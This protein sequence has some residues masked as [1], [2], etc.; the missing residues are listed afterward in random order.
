MR[1]RYTRASHYGGIVRRFQPNRK[2][3][4]FRQA[5]YI[6]EGRE[7]TQ[8]SGRMPASA[9]AGIDPKR[10]SDAK[11]GVR[12]AVRVQRIGR[13]EAARRFDIDTW[14]VARMRH[15]RCRLDYF[16]Q[17]RVKS[18]RRLA[19]FGRFDAAH[20]GPGQPERTAAEAEGRI[21]I[22]FNLE[23]SAD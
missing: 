23:F 10:T 7:A 6:A 18:S 15:H 21:F 2:N 1:A 4:D 12:C 14:T 19:L 11:A 8:S 9:T 22:N 17:R 3:P 13:R 16:R 5:T 20:R